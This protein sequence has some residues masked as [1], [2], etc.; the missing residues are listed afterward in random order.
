M[1]HRILRTMFAKGIF[2]YPMTKTDS[3]L[4][5]DR[6]VAEQDAEQAIVLLKNTNAMLPIAK[7]VH[8]IAIIGSHADIGMLAGGGSSQ[9]IPT[10]HDQADEFPVGGAVRP[11]GVKIY[12]P[13]SP[14]A[15]LQAEVP[16]A[17]VTYDSGVD[18]QNAAALARQ[19]DVVI[20]F[21]EQWMTEGRD[22]PNLSLPGNQDALI[23]AVVAANPRTI[24]VLETGGPVLMPWLDQVPAVLAAWYA[25]SGG[26][27]ALARILFGDVNPSGKLPITFPQGVDQLPRPVL[28]S[29][30]APFDIDYR[31]GANVGYRWFEWRNLKPLFPFG[32]GLSYSTFR[33]DSMQVQGGETIHVNVDVT[34]SGSRQGMETVQAYATPP[35]ASDRAVP[36]LIGWGKVDLKPGETRRVTIS[37]DP[38]LFAEFDE[39]RH[40]WHLPD[41]Q[42]AV[43]VG[44]SS[45]S[46]PLA[47]TVQL[48]ARD[49]PP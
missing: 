18:L 34:N 47:A 13:P 42:Y 5:A 28:P 22:V 7:T 23:A 4:E 15:A 3:N 25:G 27:T 41:G 45:A 9:V 31:E 14:L 2:D 20:V 36:R 48:S 37:A 19:S 21:V 30:R 35:D 43:A 49:L 11:T 1:V 44:N 16:G 38:R 6:A 29:G 17:R 26:A 32:Y 8:N 33:I 24:V 40:V 39:A 46:L 10:G 12:D